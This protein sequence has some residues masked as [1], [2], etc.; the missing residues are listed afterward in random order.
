MP[1]G[2]PSTCT[3]T[4]PR[5]SPDDTGGKH[6]SLVPPF[7]LYFI[8][9]HIHASTG[10][11]QPLQS[12][13]ITAGTSEVENLKVFNHLSYRRDVGGHHSV[14]RTLAKHCLILFITGAVLVL[15]LTASSAGGDSTPGPL[16]PGNKDKCTVK[17]SICGGG[18]DHS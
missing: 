14:P 9:L 1:A 6:P 4:D 10:P 17:V 7:V 2:I 18:L 15:N 16:D 12:Q 3:N 13:Q 5:S 8:S 11:V